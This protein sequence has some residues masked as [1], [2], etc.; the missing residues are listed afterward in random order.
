MKKFILALIVSAMVFG[1]F[2]TAAA[3]EWQLVFSDRFNNGLFD[4][5]GE[6]KELDFHDGADHGEI[7]DIEYRVKMKETTDGS[8]D[9]SDSYEIYSSVLYADATRITQYMTD[10]TGEYVRA[11]RATALYPAYIKNADVNTFVVINRI[12]P[13]SADELEFADIYLVTKDDNGVTKELI[14]SEG[15]NR[16]ETKTTV[17]LYKSVE[18]NGQIVRTPES[19]IIDDSEYEKACGIFVEGKGFNDGL[20]L[21]SDE[22]EYQ[23]INGN[24]VF[25]TG[26]LGYTFTGYNLGYYLI[27]SNNGDS[28][29]WEKE[30]PERDR[31]HISEFKG[32]DG[33]DFNFDNANIDNFY[34]NGY[35]TMEVK[36]D[37]GNATTYLIKLK[38]PA[39]VSVVL[40]GQKIYFDQLPVIESGRTLVPLRAIFEAIGAGVDWDDNTNT[41]TAKKDDVEIKLTIDS[42]VAFKN[43]EE[44][45]LDVPARVI[46]GRTLVPVRFVADCFG[47][48][49][50]WDDSIHQVILETN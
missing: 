17:Q 31:R 21:K 46:N 42:S 14:C 20:I 19:D 41:V 40:D 8:Q 22:G 48:N 39:I 35:N 6:I 1:A 33:E 9:A 32:V 4:V 11:E 16:T 13:K 25:A 49:V 43:G 2:T 50:D 7:V 26:M 44:I 5:V 28:I 23:D 37:S 38:N 36:D 27:N 45:G 30:D 3:D 29:D 18:E 24:C 10:F 12:F 15:W 47:V 34:D